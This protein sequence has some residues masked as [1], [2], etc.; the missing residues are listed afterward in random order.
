MA[1]KIHEGFAVVQFPSSCRRAES[2]VASDRL[3]VL[4]DGE[5]QP[6]LLE[7]VRAAILMMVRA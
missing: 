6:N 7:A 2:V 1:G 4:A 3:A 5:G